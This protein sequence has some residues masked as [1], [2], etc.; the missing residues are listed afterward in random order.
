MY[1]IRLLLVDDST[2]DS[3]F[4]KRAFL[5][6][7]IHAPI[8]TLNDGHAAIEYLAGSGRFSA[9]EEYPLPDLLLLDIKMPGVDGFDVLSWVRQRPGLSVLPIIMLS[10][11]T[12]SAD[13]QKAH[14]LR[15]NSYLVKPNDVEG[16]VALACGIEKYWFR[17][18]VF[19]SCRR[20]SRTD[21]PDL[22]M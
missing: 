18:N 17:E 4:F 14:A 3:Y 12:Y 8:D 22:A 16:Y 5:R 6:A 21:G 2:D 20:R 11:S 7:G 9:W 1:H 13:I 19:P 10:S 15:A